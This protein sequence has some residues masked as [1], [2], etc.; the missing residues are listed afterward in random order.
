M[1]RGEALG[2]KQG[3]GD[4]AAEPGYIAAMISTISWP[5]RF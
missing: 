4:G 5:M 1:P 3:P 2:R